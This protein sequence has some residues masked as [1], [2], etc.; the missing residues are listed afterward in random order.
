MNRQLAYLLPAFFGILSQSSIAGAATCDMILVEEALK[1]SAPDV[2]AAALQL[3]LTPDEFQQLRTDVPQVAIGSAQLKNVGSYTEFYEARTQLARRNTF[4]YGLDSARAAVIASV[5]LATLLQWSA[6]VRQTAT[7]QGVLGLYAWISNLTPP[8]NAEVSVVWSSNNREPVTVSARKIGT[9]GFQQSFRVNPGEPVSFSIE[10]ENQADKGLVIS[11]EGTFVTVVIPGSSATSTQIA[12]DP[13]QFERKL[14]QSPSILLRSAGGSIS[15][16]VKC[17]EPEDGWSFEPYSARVVISAKGDDLS[18]AGASL[19]NIIARTPQRICFELLVRPTVAESAAYITAYLEASETRP[20]IKS[21]QVCVGEPAGSCQVNA[22]NLSCGGSVDQLAKERCSSSF[23]TQRISARDGGKCGYSV[24][25][26]TCLP[27]APPSQQ[28]QVRRP[29]RTFSVCAGN[30]GGPSC[31]GDNAYY[32]CDQYNAM[33]GGAQRTYTEL[34]NRLCKY[35]DNG[36]EKIGNASVV[37]L[38]SVSGG[39]CGWTR[40]SVTCTYP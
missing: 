39:Q 7:A 1:R 32:T 5:P 23:T 13:L 14:W 3:V 24:F 31:A 19:A 38:S 18:G 9:D 22:S 28:S 21:F 8:R 27:S 29:P 33:G 26:V 35:N 36:Q 34:G 15:N 11:A 37:H 16:S 40:F 30:G 6:C 25:Q 10:R 12:V 20:L 2:Q 4:V 17:I